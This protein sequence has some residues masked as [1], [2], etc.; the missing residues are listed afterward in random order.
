MSTLLL[1]SNRA[2]ILLSGLALAGCMSLF[3][4]NQKKIQP[5]IYTLHPVSPRNQQTSREASAPVLVLVPRPELPKGFETE[6][7][8]LLFEPDHRLDY[9]AD[10][11]W[12]ARLDD[13]LQDFIVQMALN[14]LPDRI[15]ATSTITAA[16]YKLVVKIMDF[17]PVYQATADSPPRLDVAMTVTLVVLPGE[18]MKSQFSLKKSAVSS[19]N[20]MTAVTKELESL[21]Q[22]ATEE[23]LQ[24]IAALL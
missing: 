3:D 8:T 21:L 17:Q 20:T 12:S 16:R 13:L 15:A 5:S 4:T 1:T 18:T 23:M 14:I 19:A 24:K 22:S 10:A 7:I 11:K 6:R 2:F 9:F